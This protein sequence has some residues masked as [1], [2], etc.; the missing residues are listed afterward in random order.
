MKHF[1]TLLTLLIFLKL[2]SSTDFQCLG[3]S[4]AS[5]RE[6]YSLMSLLKPN[7]TKVTNCMKNFAKTDKVQYNE[8]MSAIKI[9]ARLVTHLNNF[10]GYWE[11]EMAVSF[12]V[13][14]TCREFRRTD[15]GFGGENAWLESA[16]LGLSSL[17][18]VF[19]F[20]FIMYKCITED[21]TKCIDEESNTVND[22]ENENADSPS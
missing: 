15:R 4:V 11:P 18:I 2:V 8:C 1:F 16:T 22:N 5:Q 6:Y 13:N 12:A 7:M 21:T 9:P 3:L 19:V 17:I 20:F 10:S 14:A